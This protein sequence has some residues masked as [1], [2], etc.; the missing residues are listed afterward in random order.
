MNYTRTS[1]RWWERE[2]MGNVPQPKIFGEMLTCTGIIH[3]TL[4]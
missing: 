2:I 1:E 4:A 3:Y